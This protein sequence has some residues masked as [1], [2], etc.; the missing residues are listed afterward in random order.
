MSISDL[1]GESARARICMPTLRTFNRQVFRCGLY[2][3]EDVLT[4]VDAVDLI[5]LT[6]GP[7]FTLLD[8]LQKR[9]VYRDFSE[10]FIYANPGLTPVRLTQ[11]YDLFVVM[12]QFHHDLAYVNA[13]RNWKDRCKTS[14]CWID[15][16]WSATIFHSRR[17]LTALKQFDHVIIGSSSNSVDK[18]SQ[19]V[20]RDCKWVPLGVDTLHFIPYPGNLPRSIDVCGIG[21]L[22]DRVHRALRQLA[23][24]ENIFYLHDTCS[25]ATSSV[26][27]HRQHRDQLANFSRRARCFLVAPAKL[28]RE[29]ETSGQIE[30]GPRFFEAAAGGSVLLGQSPDCSSFRELFPWQDAV[31][32]ITLDGS[33]VAEKLRELESDPKRQQQIR[34]RNVIESL[35]RHDWV[36]RWKKIYE[37][38]GVRV[39]SA[40]QAR[41]NALQKLAGD[42]RETDL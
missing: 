29:S 34:Q 36:Y 41:V 7:N 8:W 38:A 37:I 10:T 4:Q 9:I 18:L 42:I 32:E 17:W 2:E 40:M 21:R 11:D 20:G 22:P 5:P 6:P 14:V 13:I 30:F 28:D 15:E 23:L 3:A 25:I 35:L 19:T 33:D 12:C 31:V 26:T 24:D 39:P 27:D 1:G 16:C